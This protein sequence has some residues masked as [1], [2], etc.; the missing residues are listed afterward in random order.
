MFLG[1][2]NKQKDIIAAKDN[3]GQTITYG[4][5]VDKCKELKEKQFERAVVF[6]M[7][8]NTVGSLMAYLTSVEAELVPVTLSAGIDKELFESLYH[9]Y[10]PKYIWCDDGEKFV[11]RFGAPIHTVFDFVLYETGNDIYQI[12]DKLQLLMTTSGSTGS[13]KLVRYRIGNL[14]SNAK[15]V[16]AA[17]GWTEKEKSICD[18]AMNYTMGLNII[19]SHLYV[20]ATCLLTS[21]NLTS[22]DFWK[23]VKEEKGTN[24]CGVPFSYDILKKLRFERMS[25]PYLTTITEGGGKLT[26]KRFYELATYANENGKRFIA[27]FGTTETSARMAVLPA[28]WALLKVGSIGKAI[29]EGEL[30]LVDD[31]NEIISESIAEGEL[32]YKGPNVTMG[33]AICKEDLLKDDEFNGVYRTGD[34]ARRDE[35]GF[36]FITGRIS[37]FLKLLSYRVSLDQSEQLIQ[38]QFSIECACSGNDERMNIYITN[39]LY[40]DSVLDFISKKTGLFKS[41][42]KVFVIPQIIRNESGKIRYKQMDEIYAKEL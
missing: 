30:F 41:L 40:R 13:P 1:V 34:M 5:I 18:L 32:C 39:E 42:F 3:L 26:D 12:N 4:E 9:T 8:K 19:N 6:I 7:C 28:E 25:L 17:F 22:S 21:Y 23:Y 24:Y 14:E 37:R 16:A 33:Y 15:N 29:P 10:Q 35:D 31:N 2:D 38:Q 11:Q 27:S 20:G 36:Y